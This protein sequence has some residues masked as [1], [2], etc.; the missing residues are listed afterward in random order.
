MSGPVMG[1][2]GATRDSGDGCAVAWRD[3][4]FSQDPVAIINGSALKEGEMAGPY[5]VVKILAYSVTLECEGE[6]V[7]L[8]LK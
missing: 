6:E 1:S 7:E 4:L 8:R 2:S 5:R 3:L